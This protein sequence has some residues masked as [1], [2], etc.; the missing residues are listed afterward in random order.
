MVYVFVTH[1][2]INLYNLDETMEQFHFEI[3]Q[4]LND[5]KGIYSY[6]YI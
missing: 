5:T 2:K 6:V 3:N 4:G 1:K